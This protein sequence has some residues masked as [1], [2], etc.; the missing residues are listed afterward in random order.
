[1]TEEKVVDIKG[2]SVVSEE[3][4]KE[5]EHID[6]CKETLARAKAQT[7][8]SVIVVGRTVDG[9]LF[10]DNSNEYVPTIVHMLE[11][12]KLKVMGF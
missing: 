7:L 11:L 9:Q 6:A 10:V 1:M 12:S 5:L 2:N 4:L 8:T 3:K